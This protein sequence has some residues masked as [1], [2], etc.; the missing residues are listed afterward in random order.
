[1]QVCEVQEPAAR[2]TEPLL[3]PMQGCHSEPVMHPQPAA[4]QTLQQRGLGHILIRCNTAGSSAMHPVNACL[5]LEFLPDSVPEAG[6]AIRPSRH[7][8]V[9]RRHQRLTP[10]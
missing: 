5:L 8:S 4:T 10:L 7:E 6:E 9:F 3:L 2:T 1:M